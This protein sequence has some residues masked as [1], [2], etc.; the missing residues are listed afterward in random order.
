MSKSFADIQNEMRDASRDLED[1]LFKEY[2][3]IVPAPKD[4]ILEWL[5]RA[6]RFATDWKPSN[7]MF[8]KEQGKI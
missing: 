7:S 4:R 8:L 5:E 3:G 6:D 2:W 1:A